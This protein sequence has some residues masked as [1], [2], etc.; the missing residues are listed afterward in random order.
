MCVLAEGIKVICEMHKDVVP[1]WK[2]FPSQFLLY[3]LI[4]II[5]LSPLQCNLF[6]MTHCNVVVNQVTSSDP[7]DHFLHFHTLGIIRNLT[8][9]GAHFYQAKMQN[10]TLSD[11]IR[12]C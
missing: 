10:L 7:L 4:S 6:E 8:N 1:F 2:I 9:V 12:V 5:F 11:T 3:L